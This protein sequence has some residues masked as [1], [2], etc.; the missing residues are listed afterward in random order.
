MFLRLALKSRLSSF[1]KSPIRLISHT[2]SMYTLLLREESYLLILA[3]EL[4]C[5][6][7]LASW[8]VGWIVVD[9]CVRLPAAAAM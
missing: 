7:G 5:S 3:M 4:E 9:D 8:R 2:F 1:S 6:D